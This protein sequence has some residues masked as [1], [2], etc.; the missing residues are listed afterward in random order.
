MS[1]PDWHLF[2]TLRIVQRIRSLIVIL[3]NLDCYARPDFGPTVHTEP[4]PQTSPEPEPGGADPGGPPGGTKVHRP[5]TRAGGGGPSA[6]ARPGLVGHA[7]PL[8]GR[9]RRRREDFSR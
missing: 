9:V 1:S 4:A 7:R 3:R 8:P 2:K 5:R 6:R